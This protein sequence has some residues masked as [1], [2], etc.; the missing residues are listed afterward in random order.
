MF[1]KF[2]NTPLGYAYFRISS[3]KNDSI[4]SIDFIEINTTFKKITGLKQTTLSRLDIQN[5]VTKKGFDDFGW[6]IFHKHIARFKC[7][8]SFDLYSP[9]QKRW[10]KVHLSS[11][12]KL[13]F[14]MLLTDITSEKI[15]INSS[16]EFLGNSND[17]ID[18]KKLCDDFLTVCQAKYVSFNLFDENGKDFTTVAFSGVN[19]HF[20]KAIDQLGFE[21]VGKKWFYDP[22][23]ADKIKGSNLVRFTNLHDL[24]GSV[25]PEN[26]IKSIERLFGVGETCV[27][28]IMKDG[29]MLGD[30][31]IIMPKGV[32][33]QN[34][35]TAE[36]FAQQVGL[37]I[38]KKRIENELKTR[39]KQIEEQSVQATILAEQATQANNAKSE[40]LANMSHEIRTPL[41]GIIGMTGL[42][43]DTKLT[44]EQYRFASTIKSSGESLLS[45]ITDILDLSKIE[46][47]RL[48]LENADFDIYKLLDNFSSMVSF[49]VHEKGLEFTCTIAPEVP[50]YLRGDPDRL[51]QILLNLTVNAIKFTQDGN[52]IIK[53]SILTENKDH[54]TLHFSVSDTG[55][56]IPDD[57]QYKL[58]QKFT[59]VDTS[60]SRKFGG[61]GLGLVIAKQLAEL[62][63]GKIG[64]TS[65]ESHGSE[66]W[67]TACFEKAEAESTIF[68]NVPIH[69]ATLNPVT[70]SPA[71][72]KFQDPLCILLVEDNIINQQVATALLNKLGLIPDSV[73]N[74]KE[75]IDALLSK[76]YDLI[77]MDIQMPEMDGFEA[78]RIIRKSTSSPNHSIP[79]VAM[80]A[81]A[82]HG[83]RERCMNAGMNDYITKPVTIEKLYEILQKW[84][85]V[86]E[87]PL[88][89]QPI[90][91]KS[92]DNP[93]IDM[94]ELFD[95][96]SFLSR[97][98]NDHGLANEILLSYV[99]MQ[100]EQIDSIK[101]ALM[102]HNW[103][104]IESLAHSI[105]GASG[106]ISADSVRKIAMEIETACRNQNAEPIP[107]LISELELRFN[108]TIEVI[109]RKATRH[110]SHPDYNNLT[111][112]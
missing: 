55:I 16:Q 90:S 81:N 108:E 112:Q 12:Q 41:N 30:F 43:L 83:D 38:D 107:G 76:H 111:D 24:T 73:K 94:N 64:F 5:S 40:F 78:T 95:Y 22:V 10:Y 7:S 85:K 89:Q 35:I 71:I 91:T 42:L 70:A 92:P 56:G 98:V 67:F 84:L 100:P 19:K 13:H 37:M 31:T 72:L 45:L 110:T 26:I 80:T 97:I 68:T 4:H 21:I 63:G 101:N 61:T 106:N 15:V 86:T 2:K 46:A 87:A 66:F 14:V 93:A 65:K 58:F 69:S 28:K 50:M 25:L 88:V 49:Q 57:K 20:R 39:K 44:Q 62:M 17:S 79:I 77:L 34:E 48:E 53:I 75:A 82:M 74:G 104:R 52:V 18:Y 36:L 29:L 105:K 33:L 51:R 102:E 96:S 59:Q 9:P 99:T 6:E 11:P 60:V 32:T 54:I 27:L 3:N 47:G 103:N 109:K 1:N 23:R 8:N